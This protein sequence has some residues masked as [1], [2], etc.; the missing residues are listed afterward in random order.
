[1]EVCGGESEEQVQREQ[2]S[3]DGL[4]T[5]SVEEEEEKIECGKDS[6]RREEREEREEEEEREEVAEEEEEKMKE[7]PP[8]P[9]KEELKDREEEDIK[10]TF[11]GEVEERGGRRETLE[12]RGM[13]TENAVVIQ[14][15]IGEVTVT[16]EQVYTDTAPPYRKNTLHS[17]V[18]TYVKLSHVMLGRKIWTAILISGAYH[19]QLMKPNYI[20]SG[21]PSR[22]GCIYGVLPSCRY[23]NRLCIRHTVCTVATC[24]TV[25]GRDR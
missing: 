11:I 13:A 7:V 2:P 4:T 14:E 15:K 1:M 12:E 21:A 8:Q 16:F 24:P 3:R 6:E 19:T 25:G 20:F 5:L 17:V 18:Q 9:E 22:C 10:A 23:D